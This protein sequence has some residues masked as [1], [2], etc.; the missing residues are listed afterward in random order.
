MKKIILAVAVCACLV[1][2]MALAARPAKSSTFAWCTAKNMC[3]M[4]FATKKRKKI[5]NLSLYSK[6][7]SVPPMAAGY[8]DMKVD[9][10]GKFSGSGSYENVIGET[11]QY[12]IKGKFRTKKKA[13][14]TFDVD[15]ADCKDDAT[16][17]V[18]KR[19]GPAS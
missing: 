8:K 1:P 15:S 5:V 3:P 14:G 4:M 18:A 7:A 16:K 6:C 19:T 12:E 9:R 11:V 17:F 2:A 10:K 13:V